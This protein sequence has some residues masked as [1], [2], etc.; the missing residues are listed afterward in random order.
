[1]QVR[2]PDQALRTTV[3]LAVALLLS[4][5]LAGCRGP[6][7]GSDAT[8]GGIPAGP[9]SSSPPAV[10]TSP[11]VSP[12][13]ALDEQIHAVLSRMSLAD[14]VGQ[15]FVTY[16]YGDSA[17]T[18]YPAYTAKNRTLYGVRNGAE[19]VDR[20]R[21][22]GVIYFG[23]AGNLGAPTRIAA[24]STGLQRRAMAHRP[25]VPLLI[26]TDQEGGVVSRI[27]PP[28]ASSPGNLAIGA[29]FDVATAER[30]AAAAGQQLRALGIN[31]DDAPVVDVNSN[32]RNITD[33]PRAFGDRAGV[34][35][36]FAAAAVR[37][38]Q[39]AGV[40]ATA[41][42]FPGLGGTAVNTDNGVAVTRRTRAQLLTEDLAPFRAAIAAGTDLVMSAHVVVPALDATG[43][44]ASLS[45]PILTGLLRRELGYDGVVTTDAMDAAALA[46][47]PPAQAAVRA[48]QAG[49]DLV[50]MPQ[51]LGEAVRAVT[52]AVRR[53][54][55]TA[56]RLDESVIRILTLKARLGLFGHPY[57]APGAAT[58]G[59]GTAAQRG[60]MADAARRAVTLLRNDRRALPLTARSG[61][62][63]LVTGWGDTQTRVLAAR[64][65][66]HG[67]LPRRLVTGKEPGAAGIA[68]A[69][70]AARQADVVVV[71]TSDAWGDGGQRRLVGA[72]LLG[73][74]PVVVVA[75]G[76]PYD[77][78][79]LGAVSA[80]VAA[81]GSQPASVTAA[82]DV[83]FGAQPLGRLPVTVPAAG[84]PTRILY[85]YGTGLRY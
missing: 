37:G 29:T 40:A 39:G 48:V 7:G 17:T 64:M 85:P 15:L 76:G 19:V 38:Y 65:A 10:P 16:V 41:K 32:P 21:L 79:Y 11:T 44:P 22:G 47:I 3:L 59:V 60:T 61:R 67:A 75:L 58:H 80:F 20:Y 70:A 8:P 81:Y 84:H 31:T 46:G 13:S 1:M 57:P 66:A 30:T 51:N 77:V 14:K 69:V 55:V 49:N 82:A 24:L 43:S 50:L 18:T 25:A 62:R 27:G 78:A 23:W 5:P 52:D 2:A 33:G 73:G 74:R 36:R 72:L 9:P 6:S 4:A 68:A 45:K 56:G 34:V 35:G 42:H 12:P 28:V 26:S 63:V 53:G 54:A 71:T 83:L